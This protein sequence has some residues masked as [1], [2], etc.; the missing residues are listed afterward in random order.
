[1]LSGVIEI[2]SPLLVTPNGR[3]RVRCSEYTSGASDEIKLRCAE[4]TKICPDCASVTCCT[5]QFPTSL[6]VKP[7]EKPSFCSGPTS[8]SLFFTISRRNPSCLPLEIPGVARG[9]AAS[10]TPVALAEEPTNEPS[11]RCDNAPAKLSCSCVMNALVESS[12]SPRC[13]AIK[14]RCNSPIS[15]G[16]RG[17]AD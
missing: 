5:I 1:M 12:R 4:V 3:A 15:C 8:N 10:A 14:H 13:A 16:R 17:D 6:P 7:R 2:E 9:A 11:P